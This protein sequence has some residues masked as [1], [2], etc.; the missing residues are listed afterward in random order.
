MGG[1]SATKKITNAKQPNTFREN[2]TSAELK[3]KRLLGVDGTALTR[4]AIASYNCF[5][6]TRGLDNSVFD[7]TVAADATRG[8]VR[9]LE[10]SAKALPDGAHVLVRAWERMHEGVRGRLWRGR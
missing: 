8:A 2:R 6:R 1:A 10:G 7:D 5:L 4:D 3:N 9:S